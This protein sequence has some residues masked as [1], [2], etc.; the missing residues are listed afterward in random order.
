MNHKS[1]ETT[2]NMLK[3]V[4]NQLELTYNQHSAM[5]SADNAKVMEIA[6]L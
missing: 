2:K 3:D 1:V 4:Q 6:I 5:H